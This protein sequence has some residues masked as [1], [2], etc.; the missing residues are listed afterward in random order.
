M[1]IETP[2]DGD[3]EFTV[4]WNGIGVVQVVGMHSELHQGLAELDENIGIVVDP[5]QEH[6][7]IQ[8]RDS[9]VHET[10]QGIRDLGR[11]LSG[12]VAVHDHP[13]RSM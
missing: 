13:D 12:V 8:D 10:M 6:G 4:A 7:L 9:R 2:I 11:E 3:A 1:N 5:A